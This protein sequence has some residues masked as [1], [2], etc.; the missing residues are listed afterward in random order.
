[1]NLDRL[2]TPE[3]RAE[4]GRTLFL[5]CLGGFLLTGLFWG[6]G[7]WFFALMLWFGGVFT[8]LRVVMEVY[9][10]RGRRIAAAYRKSLP[11]AV[12]PRNLPLV[13]RALVDREVLMPRIVTPPQA[14]KVPEAA[15]AIGRRTFQDRDCAEGVR[16]GAIRFAAAVDGG[17]IEMTLPDWTAADGQNIQARWLGIRVLSTMAATARVLVALY[18]ELTHQPFTTATFDGDR[19]RGFLDEALAYL[20]RA[21]IDL[22]L[23][24]FTAAPLALWTPEA[25]ALRDSWAAFLDVPSPAPSRLDVVLEHALAPDDRPPAA[26]GGP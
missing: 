15:A 23:S 26:P 4:A 16:L 18:E 24:A 14:A 9:G 1:M 22:D 20:D 5:G 6:W 25:N 3:G 17:M 7:H 2:Q 12:T 13:A 11:E 19:L 8:P 10:P 21:A